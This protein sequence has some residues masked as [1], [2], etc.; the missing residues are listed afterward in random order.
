M[1]NSAEMV[2]L[3]GVL[4]F[5]GAATARAQLPRPVVRYAN[6]I[7]WSEQDRN[8]RAVVDLAGNLFVAGNSGV[9]PARFPTATGSDNIFLLKIDSTGERVLYSKVL[10]KGVPLA[11]ASDSSGSVYLMGTADTDFATTAGAYSANGDC[12]V[13]KIDPSGAALL[14]ST[15]FTCSLNFGNPAALAIDPAGNAY[16]AGNS[17]EGLLTT[18]GA[19]RTSGSGAF[20]AKINPQGSKLLYATY[21]PGTSPVFVSSQAIAVDTLGYAY[22]AGAANVKGFPPAPDTFPH[23]SPTASLVSTDVMVVK[24]SPDGDAVVFAALFGGSGPDTASGIAL[25]PDGSIFVSGYAANPITYLGDLAP[26]LP[27]PVTAGA[28]DT[29]SNSGKGFLARLSPSGDSLLFS[30]LL[31]DTTGSSCLSVTDAG[32]DLIASGSGTRI[33]RVTADGGSIINSSLV[34]LADVSCSQAGNNFS[35]LGFSGPLSPNLKQ[36]GSGKPTQFAMVSANDPNAPQFDVDTGE[37]NLLGWTALDGS[38]PLITQTITATSEGQPVPVV[39]GGASPGDFATTPVEIEVSTRQGRYSGSLVLFAPGAKDGLVRLKANVA[40]AFGTFFFDPP[41]LQFAAENSTATAI[42]KTVRVTTGVRTDAFGTVL[43]LPQRYTIRQPVPSWLDIK[44]SGA[45]PDTLT[46][47]VN[48][49][50]LTNNS[51]YVVPVTFQGANAASQ[52]VEGQLPAF[53]Q[54]GP[55]IDFRKPFS[56]AKLTFRYTEPSQRQMSATVHLSTPI[57]P[58]NFLVEGFANGTVV[59]PLSG[60]TPADITVTIARPEGNGSFAGQIVTNIDRYGRALLQIQ[61]DVAAPG[62]VGYLTMMPATGYI[63]TSPVSTAPGSLAYIKLNGPNVIPESKYSAPSGVASLAGY[64]FT[65]NG[66]PIT[67]FNYDSGQFLAQM[68]YRLQQGVAAIDAFD[69]S[70]MRV[71]TVP[72]RVLPVAPEFKGER[73]R[74]RARNSAGVEIDAKTPIAPGDVLTVQ[75]TG[76]GMLN[77]SPE[78]GQPASAG[79]PS[80]PVAAVTATVGGK[81]A[82]LI[83]A[84]ASETAPGVVD[85][86]IRTPNLYNGD[87]YI[88]VG[89]MGIYTSERVPIKVKNR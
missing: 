24:L 70:G 34:S 40:P 83:S 78:E 56:P 45:T 63:G 7:G 48:P 69:G 17:S 51:L 11:I 55:P 18:S 14:Y 9:D 61:L 72:V 85:L 67:L 44:G 89:A 29:A 6:A 62:Y 37:F 22:I 38:T 33:L 2:K 52:T 16:I 49:K 74:L 80:I 41:Q 3:A 68:P 66:V 25:A 20:V 46:I 86:S 36:I 27:F 13:S 65:A 88:S 59:S 30:T 12:F 5:C 50:A 79:A 31:S 57:D 10:G 87:H 28:A 84:R 35:L 73:L 76:L 1:R 21:L 54:L 15:R 23:E 58:V 42:Q 53:V 8:L 4:L 82:E 64:S 71:A 77:P 81:K 19:Y 39:I 75:V 43:P 60:R 32:V 26:T 47:T